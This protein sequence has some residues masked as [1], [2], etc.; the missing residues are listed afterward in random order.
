MPGRLPLSAWLVIIIEGCERFAYFGLS[1][2]L[3]NYLQN[4]R[5]DP[6]ASGGLG[7]GFIYPLRPDMEN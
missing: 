4:S 2:P 5:N 1:G 3:Q 6:L 7:S